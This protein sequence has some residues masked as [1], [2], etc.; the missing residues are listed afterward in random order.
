[1]HLSVKLGPGYAFTFDSGAGDAT[2]K[3]KGNKVVIKGDD[4]TLKIKNGKVTLRTG[5]LSLRIKANNIPHGRAW[6][7]WNRQRGYRVLGWTYVYHGELV[8][9]VPAG[10][11]ADP[12]M[13]NQAEFRKM[14][15]ANYLSTTEFASEF[16]ELIGGWFTNHPDAS[17]P[18]TVEWRYWSPSSGSI[19]LGWVKVEGDKI[20][21][22]VFKESPI[23][24]RVFI[25][26]VK[27]KL[28]IKIKTRD[29]KITLKV[30]LN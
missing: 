15:L 2:L 14:V 12:G 7:W 9:K 28:K 26:Y 25:R 16:D 27:D 21:Y 20:T 11:E 10:A 1:M 5:N 30:K 8:F 18:E 4:F 22:A 17:D 19:L 24:D 13:L 6:G 3:I 23:S 29:V